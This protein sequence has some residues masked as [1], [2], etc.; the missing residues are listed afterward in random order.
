MVDGV[1]RRLIVLVAGA[2]CIAGCGPEST[3]GDSDASTEVA[4]LSR[5]ATAEPE[6]RSAAVNTDEPAGQGDQPGGPARPRS[7]EADNQSDESDSGSSAGRRSARTQ[8]A[9]GDAP[10]DAPKQADA[11]GSGD[12]GEEGQ[13][14]EREEASVPAPVEIPGVRSDQK[15][16]AKEGLRPA[17]APE[18]IIGV[19]SDPATEAT[20]EETDEE[21]AT[22]PDEETATEPD[23]ERPERPAGPDNSDDS[24]GAN[25][26]A[27]T[28]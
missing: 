27:E 8:N 7:V 19:R 2:L 23:E 28:S 3:R 9:P 16:P 20:D 18:E 14:P 24:E 21:T 26:D 25:N 22:E 4:R 11:P 13:A 12:A 15:P 5:V 6:S 17:E 10:G 1:E